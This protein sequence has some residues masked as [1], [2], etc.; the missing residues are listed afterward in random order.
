MNEQ[1]NGKF[2]RLVRKLGAEPFKLI[3]ELRL[4]VHACRGYQGG[5]RSLRRAHGISCNPDD[6]SWETFRDTILMPKMKAGIPGGFTS[7]PEE[8]AFEVY[9]MQ[10]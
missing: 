6:V 9:N 10:K 7:P 4:Y 3:D 2:P 5:A 1:P 8:R